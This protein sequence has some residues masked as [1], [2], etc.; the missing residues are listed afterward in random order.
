MIE[1]SSIG[2]EMNLLKRPI[3]K[4]TE[5]FNNKQVRLLFGQYLLQNWHHFVRQASPRTLQSSLR[6]YSIFHPPQLLQVPFRALSYLK[7]HIWPGLQLLPGICILTKPGSYSSSSLL[8]KPLMQL[9]TSCNNSNLMS[10]FCGRFGK[11]LFRTSLSV[12]KSC[13]C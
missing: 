11:K 2:S 13:M 6:R 3:S 4:M 12:L 10:Q 8:R 1:K 5:K 9:L 7:H